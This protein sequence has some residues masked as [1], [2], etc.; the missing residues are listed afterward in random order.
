LG[1]KMKKIAYLVVC[2]FVGSANASLISEEYNVTTGSNDI[3]YF[4]FTVTGA[5]DF[6]I[7][8]LGFSTLG[9]GY[10]NDTRLQLFHTS[11]D[12]VNYING[13]DDGGIGTDAQLSTF[14]DLGNYI[15]A[16]GDF[17]FSAA[18]AVAGIGG[19]VE[20]PGG[21]I[22]AQVSSANGIAVRTNVVPEPTSLALLA[23]GLAGV[24]FSRKKK[25]L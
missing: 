5:G 14:L 16:V 3:Y 17:N 19:Y 12:L 22:R 10:D 2:L 7:D 8:A 4:D 25:A 9:T 20:A 1:I 11:L 24:G 23:L 18:S 6:T 21:L 13:N 15:M